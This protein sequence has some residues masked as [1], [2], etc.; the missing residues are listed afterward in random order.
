MNTKKI[1]GI[2]GLVGMAGIALFP[3]R[4]AHAQPEGGAADW[5]KQYNLDIASRYAAKQ[6]ERRKQIASGA[7]LAQAPVQE[8]LMGKRY[9][10][11]DQWDVISFQ[12][13][14]TEI[15]KGDGI[16]NGE[17]RGRAA[18][19]HYQVTSVNPLTIE[20][21]QAPILGLKIVDSDVTSI[22]L[23]YDQ[24]YKEV[25]KTYHLANHQ[26]ATFP[27]GEM[28]NRLI[29][30]DSFPLE[31]PSISDSAPVAATANVLPKLPGQL[32]QLAQQASYA[33][34]FASS[35]W[36]DDDDFFGRGVQVLWQ[37]NSPW[38]SYF[39]TPLGTSILVRGGL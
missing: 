19:F 12:N 2:A 3:G 27:A 29:P 30:L 35:K 38:P 5:L 10:V 25:S 16:R 22:T 17:V 4:A 1:I 9:N 8:A 39:S 6:Q 18:G 37:K 34:D 24:R 31:V 32:A 14:N 21:T 13:F 20:I 23:S 33:P 11:G 26:S 36:I 15:A 28:R 7:L